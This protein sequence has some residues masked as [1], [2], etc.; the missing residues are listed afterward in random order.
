MGVPRLPSGKGDDVATAVVSCL[1][2]WGVAERV[3]GMSF[4]TT[5]SNTG[6][7]AGAC[8]Y[9]QQRLGRNLLHLAC[10][11]HILEI[12][13][14]KTFGACL[15]KL[16]K[17]VEKN[18]ARFVGRPLL[19]DAGRRCLASSSSKFLVDALG[20]SEFFEV[21]PAEWPER[22]DYQLAR[23]RA[24][25]LKVVNDFAE[26]GVALIQSY[27]AILTKDEEQRQFLL[28]VVEEHRRRFPDVRKSTLDEYL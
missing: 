20:P 18:L 24:E 8:T 10:R 14:D 25:S 23:R 11:H 4:D 2:N 17:A 26:R 19:G 6:V 13:A 21:D 27:C 5:A 16:T 1:E 12:V 7:R 3:V 9:V 28:Q 15:F 22:Q